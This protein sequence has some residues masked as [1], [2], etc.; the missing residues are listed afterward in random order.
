ML[1]TALQPAPPTPT[2]VTRGWRGTI[3]AGLGVFFFSVLVGSSG[4][5]SAVEADGG[6]GCCFGGGTVMDGIP[7]LTGRVGLVF[8]GGRTPTA[9]NADDGTC[10][11]ECP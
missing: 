2:T 11:L 7:A 10:L 8:A 4:S 3:I 1:F 5:F 6:G 9:G